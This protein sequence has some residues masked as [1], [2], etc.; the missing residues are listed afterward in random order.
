MKKLKGGWESVPDGKNT[1]YL[2]SFGQFKIAV[3]LWHTPRGERWCVELKSDLLFTSYDL[4]KTYKTPC[5]ARRGAVRFIHK[6]TQAWEDHLG[7]RL[8]QIGDEAVLANV[9]GF[10]S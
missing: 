4:K 7:V 3:Y 9:T 8:L 5:G 6:L 1:D 10:E 2:L